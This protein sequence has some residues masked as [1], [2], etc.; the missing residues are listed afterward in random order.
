MLYPSLKISFNVYELLH[1]QK[2]IDLKNKT[3]ADMIVKNILVN[4]QFFTFYFQLFNLWLII[5]H[6]QMYLKRLNTF[7]ATEC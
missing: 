2:N 4:I 3:L 7:I 5:L 1:S 6:L